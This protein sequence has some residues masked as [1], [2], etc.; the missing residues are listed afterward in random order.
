MISVNT[1][2]QSTA[3]EILCSHV[4][5]LL[6]ATMYDNIMKISYED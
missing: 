5:F 1:G 6:E 3:L 4:A 2:N